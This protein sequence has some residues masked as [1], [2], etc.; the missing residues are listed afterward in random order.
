[1]KTIAI[2]IFCLLFNSPV[3]AGEVI[4][5]QNGQPT[6]YG[7]TPNGEVM[8]ITPNR[9]EGVVG[10][11][12]DGSLSGLRQPASGPVNPSPY[13]GGTPYV[14]GSPYISGSPYVGRNRNSR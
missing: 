13:A 10:N 6:I 2:L 3:L 11:P 4:I 7:I 1:M 12:Q 5:W 14:S 9:L 8:D